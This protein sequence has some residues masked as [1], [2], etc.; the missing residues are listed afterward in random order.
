MY[1]T[2]VR[3]IVYITQCYRVAMGTVPVNKT[4]VRH[5]VYV[6]QIYR[7][8]MVTVPVNKTQVRHIVNVTSVLL[9]LACDVTAFLDGDPYKV[10]GK[11]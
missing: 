8:A 9:K 7:V 10:S 2:Q 11:T 1:K 6:T 5:I 3:H 4:Q